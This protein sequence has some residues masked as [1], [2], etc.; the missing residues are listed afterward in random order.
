[1]EAIEGLKQVAQ[2]KDAEIAKLQKE[3]VV[4]E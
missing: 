1:M 3:A 4:P 2:V